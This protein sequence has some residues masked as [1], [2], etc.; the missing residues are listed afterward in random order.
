MKKIDEIISYYDNKSFNNLADK[1]HEILEE[2]IVLFILKP[3]S[4][5]S[6]T[7]LSEMIKIGRT[8][9]REAIKKLEFANVVEIIPRR[10]IKISELR[11]EDFYLQMEFRRLIENLIFFRAT[12]FSTPFEREHFLEMAE[13]YEE[14]LENNDVLEI[15][16]IDNEFH[17]YC[18]VCSRN[19]YAQNAILPFHSPSRRLFYLEYDV[20]QGL[21]AKINRLHID[22]M[23]AIASGDSDVVAKI[24]EELF[25]KTEDLIKLQF[26]FISN[27]SMY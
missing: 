15:V 2:L 3:G 24:T 4:T 16:R 1:A 25:E 27:K 9:V 17:H 10:G 8:P 7:E 14:A 23:R 19:P 18:I 12:K 20:N 5:Y 21:I 11:L 22:L 13:A 26:D 6:E